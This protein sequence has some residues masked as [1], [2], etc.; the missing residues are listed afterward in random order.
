MVH[1]A[2]ARLKAEDEEAAKRD[3]AAEE[4]FA[5]AASP[6]AWESLYLKYVLALPTPRLRGKA[7]AD[8]ERA[9]LQFLQT[10]GHQQLSQFL[11]CVFLAHK[12]MDVPKKFAAPA[13]DLVK[14]E[15]Y[16]ATGLAITEHRDK[17]KLGLRLHLPALRRNNT[18]AT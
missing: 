15:M 17:G 14:H 4:L 3:L 2:E 5:V 6:A 13:V 12:A 7:C 9:A 8:A 11:R 1:Q 16:A 18:F 10:G